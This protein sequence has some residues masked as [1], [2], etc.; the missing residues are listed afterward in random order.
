MRSRS[1]MTPTVAV[2]TVTMLLAT[3][4]AAFPVPDAVLADA[5]AFHEEFHVAWR[6]HVPEGGF[7]SVWMEGV[8]E[9]V[10]FASFALWYV[11][12]ETFE[13]S[14][15][16][17]PTWFPEGG[18]TLHAEA[19]D[20]IGHVTSSV[21]GE[22]TYSPLEMRVDWVPN[23]EREWL[24]VAM[25]GFDGRVTGEMRLYVDDGATLLSKTE[26]PAFLHT[27][28]DFEG[29]A[30]VVAREDLP[31]RDGI[32]EARVAVDAAVEEHAD[33]RMFASYWG[34]SH[35]DLLEMGY[36]GPDGAHDDRDS[37]LVHGGEAGDYR[38]RIDQNADWYDNTPVCRFINGE[39]CWREP[40]WV[41]GADV[42]AP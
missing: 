38:F 1:R 42:T 35:T 19:P 9:D 20:P 28:T 13:F 5:V 41:V 32:V 8:P 21:S 11:D 24:V 37:Y 40:V 17:N 3:T 15:L 39:T 30:N 26:G 36:D 18:S 10:S 29:T 27:E 33:Q 12:A 14:G 7:F 4:A 16:I 2:A 34:G 22:V 6:V 23:H 25:G 31:V